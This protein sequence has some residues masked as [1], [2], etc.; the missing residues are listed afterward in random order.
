MLSAWR[1]MRPNQRPGWLAVAPAGDCA[2]VAQVLCAPGQRPRVGWVD[3]L[4]WR[5][6][7]AALRALARRPRAASN[8]VAVLPTGAYQLLALDAPDLPRDEWRDA[9]RW[10]IKEIVDFPVEDAAI[11][12]FEAPADPQQRRRAGVFVV[13]AA[14]AAVMPLVQAAKAARRPWQ[15]VDIAETA[16]R[17]I[18]LCSAEPGR[19]E[20][21]LHV[22]ERASTLLIVA[23]GELLL[24]RAIDVSFAQLT[25]TDDQQ[26][27]L[28]FERTSLELQRTF[29]N[30]ERQFA[31]ADL[32]RLRLIPG[33]A[34][35]PFA[36]YV[37]DL[38]YLSVLPLA[39]G[40][41]IDIDGVPELADAAG[42]AAYL[43]A[44]GAALR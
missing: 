33:A 42:Q 6:P 18:A 35:A 30:V 21:L 13:A 22:G 17:N 38:I 16:L 41:V 44:V 36:A 29:D 4:D 24:S 34:L 39:L 8:M 27:Q 43:T 14:R 12:V 26:R 32:H 9:L 31:H 37:R 10:R 5:E 15:A 3:T 20:A 1:R 11:D 25:D 2:R 23:Q 7:A 19:G 40:D 28:A